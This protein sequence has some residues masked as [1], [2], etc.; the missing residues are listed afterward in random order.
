MEALVRLLIQQKQS[1]SLQKYLGG[2][3]AKVFFFNIKQ[4]IIKTRYL[5]SDFFVLFFKF[6]VDDI[7]SLSKQQTFYDC[8]SVLP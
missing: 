1:K 3:N 2:K 5:Q 6:S 4:K 7:L 8:L